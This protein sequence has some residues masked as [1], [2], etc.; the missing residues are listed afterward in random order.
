MEDANSLQQEAS[1]L[2]LA[3]SIQQQ[4]QLSVSELQVRKCNSQ[5]GSRLSMPSLSAADCIDSCGSSPDVINALD[6]VHSCGGDVCCSIAH[7]ACMKHCAHMP[8]KAD[9]WRSAHAHHKSMLL[10]VVQLALQQA[11]PNAASLQAALQSSMQTLAGQGT[12]LLQLLNMASCPFRLPA[13]ADS[14]SKAAA[15]AQDA[16]LSALGSAL[17]AVP[18]QDPQQQQSHGGAL[19][20]VVAC[21]A[22]APAA[23]QR[24]GWGSGSDAGWQVDVDDDV[25]A[26]VQQPVQAQLVQQLRDGV[27]QRLEAAMLSDGLPGELKQEVMHLLTALAPVAGVSR[28]ECR[29]AL[30]ESGCTAV[31]DMVILLNATDPGVQNNGRAARHWTP[32][33]SGTRRTATGCDTCRWPGWVADAG[34]GTGRQTAMLLSQSLMQLTPAFSPLPQ[35]QPL[36]IASGASAQAWFLKL[37]QAAE[38]E[39]Q[40]EALAGLLSLAWRHGS[41][42][43]D[44]Q[45]SDQASGF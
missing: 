11:Q 38:G 23:E 39:G 45:A 21:L 30:H 32:L 22:A 16:V 2:M 40:L 17:A 3:Q 35:L 4:C 27:W 15:M 9:G 24:D 29:H 43:P 44:S 7:L 20:G 42:L 10:Q 14:A 19:H 26:A 25:S 8:C 5:A 6:T 36:D 33:A 1:A 18:A 31:L 12:S 37:L 41:A 28:W 13:E 34:A